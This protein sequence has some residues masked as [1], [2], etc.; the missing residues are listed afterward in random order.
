MGSVMLWH[1][2]IY[3]LPFLPFRTVHGTLP[4]RTLEWV[5]IGS[6]AGKD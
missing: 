4:A 6:E 2:C 1:L 5:A 3:V